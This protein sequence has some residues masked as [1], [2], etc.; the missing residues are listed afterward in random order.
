[1]IVNKKNKQ[2]GGCDITC[3][4]EN[5]YIN[6]KLERGFI[7]V[8][9]FYS[10]NIYIYK[11]ICDKNYII[12][13]NLDKITNKSLL[14]FLDLLVDN[15]CPELATVSNKFGYPL[16]I[17]I[18]NLQQ[19]LSIKSK[20]VPGYYTSIEYCIK[21]N[22][23]ENFY[24]T[25]LQLGLPDDY[26]WS[27]HFE[28]ESNWTI[29]D[30]P[31]TTNIILK[32]LKD[33]VIVILRGVFSRET[34]YPDI[35]YTIPSKLETNNY[36][37]TNITEYDYLLPYAVGSIALSNPQLGSPN[38]IYELSFSVDVSAQ[39]SNLNIIFDFP[40]DTL[41][42]S[43]ITSDPTMTS[44]IKQKQLICTTKITSTT[45]TTYKVNFQLTN[46]VIGNYTINITA[47][48]DGAPNAGIPIYLIVTN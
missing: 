2:V 45:S 29:L 27:Y 43:N 28:E 14:C 37:A 11:L 18:A 48:L 36:T 4:A 9:R 39:N 46:L 17:D 30:N 10:E 44:I 16:L 34:I 22:S 13:I 7:K 33:K 35:H 31:T 40:F 20:V 42:L 23:G 41:G 26:L 47:D 12:T 25:V 3:D 1:M 8:I 15:P 5:L 6:L 19:P 21:N 32:E 38:T 24:N